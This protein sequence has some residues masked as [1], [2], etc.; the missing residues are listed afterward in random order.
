[1]SKIFTVMVI[2]SIK[3]FILNVQQ[4]SPYTFPFEELHI[5]LCIAVSPSSCC[6]LVLV[7][8]SY[9]ANCVTD[10]RRAAMSTESFSSYAR[11]QREG[12]D[13]YSGLTTY[14]PNIVL[15]FF[16]CSIHFINTMASY[17]RGFISLSSNHLL[18]LEIFMQ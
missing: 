5:T 1:M 3:H 14:I 13:F 17:L 18:Y 8:P 7:A 2:Y 15:L 10:F 11:F 4:L 16:L 9:T 6:L 12:C